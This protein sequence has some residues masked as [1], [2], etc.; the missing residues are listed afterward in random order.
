[1]I[2]IHVHRLKR[3]HDLKKGDHF[4]IKSNKEVFEVLSVNH[5]VAPYINEYTIKYV[6]S[7]QIKELDGKSFVEPVYFRTFG[8]IRFGDFFLS[9]NNLFVK[10]AENRALYIKDSVDVE[11]HDNDSV[12]LQTVEVC[13]YD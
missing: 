7:G 3:A 10:I 2:E 4:R 11:F 5:F 6:D 8:S 13:D 12:E 9:G 1:M